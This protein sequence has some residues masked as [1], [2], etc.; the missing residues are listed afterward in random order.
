MPAGQHAVDE[1]TQL[2]ILEKARVQPAPLAVGADVVARLFEKREIAPYRLPLHDDAVFLFQQRRYLFLQQ[3]MIPVAVLFKDV[4]DAYERK[5]F[6]FQT[7]HNSSASF[8]DYTP[9]TAVRQ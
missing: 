1:H 9:P 5:F 7:L 2:R 4:Q 8:L 3:M 6:G